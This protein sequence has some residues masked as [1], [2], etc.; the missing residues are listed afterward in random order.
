MN[1]NNTNKRKNGRNRFRV[2]GIRSAVRAALCAVALWLAAVPF[3]VSQNTNLGSLRQAVNDAGVLPYNTVYFGIYPQTYINTALML[4]G[5][6]PAIA[7]TGPFKVVEQDFQQPNGG[8]MPT[9]Q[10][11]DQ[12][13]VYNVD[14][15]RWQVLSD[16]AE[17]ILLLSDRN[18]DFQPY[19][20]IGSGWN[21]QWTS[22]TMR[23]WL[24]G[25]FL[26]GQSDNTI[27]PVYTSAGAGTNTE[28]VGTLAPS[29]S[30][31]TTAVYTSS[32]PNPDAQAPYFSVAEKDA[33]VAS[34]LTNPTMGK[35]V[36]NQ[37]TQDQVFLP[38]LADIEAAFPTVDNTRNSENTSYVNS[39]PNTSTGADDWFTR[40]HSRSPFAHYETAISYTTHADINVAAAD[41]KAVRPALRLDRSKVLMVSGGKAGVSAT[42][43]A[44]GSFSPTPA[45]PLK[46]TLVDD[47]LGFIVTDVEATAAAISAA[48]SNMPTDYHPVE[49]NGTLDISYED[50]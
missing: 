10:P 25:S 29:A 31:A 39:Y 38:S 21:G 3:A 2:C 28:D 35:D 7:P 50:V 26:G 32:S 14:P 47:Y 6:M 48:P 43:A 46:L 12:V 45:A 16:D 23:A 34:A 11:K 15:I 20:N 27:P 33:V 40:T 30:T 49:L 5:A 42:L 19:D 36:D 41:K 13:T 17:G 18:L 9:I 24:S 37:D 22:S 44:A 8:N 4:R 1:T